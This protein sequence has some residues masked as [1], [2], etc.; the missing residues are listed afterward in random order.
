MTHLQGFAIWSYIPIMETPPIDSK[1][2]NE[3]KVGFHCI[4]NY[5]T[6]NITFNSITGTHPK[7]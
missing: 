4:E 2:F 3:L 1:L 5:A 7:P 6:I